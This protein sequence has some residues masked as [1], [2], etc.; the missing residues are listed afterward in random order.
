MDGSQHYS[1]SLDTRQLERD[2][3]RA[4]KLFSDL[5]AGAVREGARIDGVFAK[6]RNAAVSLGAAWSAKELAGN[7]VRVRGEF[8]QLGVAF[9]TMLGDAG[10]ASALMA[11]LTETAARTP[12]D[13]QGVADG[14]RQLLAYGTSADKVN[15]TLIRLGNIAAGLSI[16]LGDLVYLYGTTMT[17]GRL[18]TQDLNQFTGRGI[19]MIKELAKQFGVA[20]TE[21]KG[22]VE[23]GKVGFP[24]VEKVIVSLTDQGGMFYNLMQEQSKT[25]TG[26]I[27]NIGD[28]FSMMLNDIGTSS[29]GIINA[30][31]SGVSWLIDNYE[32]VGR[33]LLELV[34]AY[35]AYRAAL[36]TVT[37][38][39]KAHQAVMVQALVNMKLAQ[40]AGEAMTRAQAMATARTKLLTAATQQL[41][42][43]LLKNPYALAAA[44][45]VAL[46]YGIYK[47]ATHQTEAEKAQE[48]L[49]DALGAAEGAASKEMST[50]RALDKQLQE[51]RKGTD[52][53]RKVKEQIVAN[54]SEYLPGLEEEIERTGSLAGK[55]E[56][57]AEAIRKASGE[58]SYAKFAEQEQ[59]KYD[60]VREEN[61]QKAYDYFI[62]TYGDQQGLEY[63]RGWLR[64]L[65]SGKEIPA[66]V[67]EAYSAARVSMGETLNGLLFDIRN[68]GELLESNLQAYRN[69][70]GLSGDGTSASVEVAFTLDGKSVSQIEEQVEKEKAKLQ[71]LASSDTATDKEISDQKAYIKTLEET[72]LERERE[73]KII[74]EIEAR[75][76]TLKKRQKETEAGSAEY[77][78]LQARIDTLSSKLPATKEER[79]AM[80]RQSDARAKAE[81]KMS[82]IILELR[83][84]AQDDEIA[85]MQD[86]TEKKLAEI[87]RDYDRQVAAIKKQQKKLAGLNKKAGVTDVNAAGLTTEQQEAVDEAGLLA[88]REILAGIAATVGEQY[89][90]EDEAMRE[91]LLK[92]GDYQQQKLAIAEEYAAKIAEAQTEG[93]KLSLG[94]ERDEALTNLLIDSGGGIVGEIFG[95]M[96][97]DMTLK[98]LDELYDRGQALMQM[99]KGGKWDSDT[100]FKIGITSDDFERLKE[101]PEFIERLAKALLDLEERAKDF[102]SP[103]EKITDGIR[104]L[105]DPEQSSN[106]EN[107]K[108]ALDDISGGLQAVSGATSFLGDTFSS[109]GEAFGND[110]MSK[111]GEGLGVIS[112]AMGAMSQ[113]AQV[114]GTLFGPIGAAAGAAI[115]LV[116]SLA[117]AFAKLHDKKNQERIDDLQD[118][119][120]D[121][122]DAYD[123]LGRKADKSYS[124][125]KASNLKLQNENLRRQQ[126]LIRQQMAEEEAKKDTD[127]EQMDE[128]RSQLKDIENQIE[129]NL[130]AIQEAVTGV[131]FDSLRDSFI[132]AV[133]DMGDAAANFTDDIEGMLRNAVLDQLFTDLYEDRLK[134]LYDNWSGYFDDGSFSSGEV[135]AMRRGLQGL[136]GDWYETVDGVDDAFGFGKDAAREQRGTVGVA[137]SMTQESA[138]ELNGRFAALQTMVAGIA[139]SI[140]VGGEDVTSMRAEITASRQIIQSCYN[141]LVDINDNTRAVVQPIRDIKAGIDDMR[142]L[143]KQSV[144]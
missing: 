16:P 21:I 123:E 15:D 119:I 39:Q 70:F 132:S 80:K 95:A 5:S 65:D 77:N 76:S 31:L 64:W 22:M 8:Q 103:L 18:Y 78:A 24:E 136:F 131:S 108:K 37:A 85:L 62:D 74:S 41:N 127:D 109:L 29:E 63:Y 73:L 99:L 67:Q 107:M 116:T 57:L 96:L 113:G 49:N 110:V 13:L 117:T 128:Y 9:T 2:M 100:G 115:G 43:A 91:Y 72:A 129:D 14:A 124:T 89:A 105:F 3:A 143:L 83:S 69:Q 53:W 82:D 79:N 52:E 19:P 75:I 92:Y 104:T 38:L 84:E 59:K 12:F 51:A 138:D 6:L 135:D 58:R 46:G 81:Q 47:L 7:I 71:E 48:R 66:K 140:K 86:G 112:D 34:A 133:D 121:L 25:I 98:E 139:E 111:I 40:A 134:Q 1:I 20:E 120:D 50:L 11:Q 114:G 45:A 17:Q 61:L 144:A 44:A 60:E 42:K 32:S 30:A 126:Q 102:R 90:A 142:V 56:E 118:Q 125:A 55:Y 36:I 28:S 93:E 106:P 130:E 54:Y 122:G 101:S 87:R 141:Q 94:K 10:K 23:A 4:E 88:V 33:T 137:E 35:G 97:D 68:Q 26:Q 27:S